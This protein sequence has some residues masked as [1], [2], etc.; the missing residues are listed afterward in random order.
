MKVVFDINQDQ[1]TFRKQFVYHFYVGAIF[2]IAYIV[3]GKPIIDLGYPGLVALLVLEI[4]ILSPLVIIHL[5]W[6]GKQLNRKFSFRNVI[7]YTEKLSIGQYIKW[8]LIGFF[9]C[10]IIYIPL[11][12][13]GL[14]IKENVFQWLPKWYF[15]PNFGTDDTGLIANVFLFAIFID[16]IL[17]P[18]LEELFFRGYLLPRMAYLKKWAPIVNGIFF[19]L[20][21]FWQPHNYLAIMGIG[22]VLSYIVWR[23]KNV[24]L[25]IFI[26]CTINIIG[27]LG[28]YLAATGGQIIP[29]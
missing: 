26:H 12:P 13:L 16:G 14:Y 1:I 24:Y 18:V 28:G 4:C 8:S 27:A 19:G 17:A 5:G 23:K 20:Y 3:I 25:G 21:H 22:V 9:G 7:A 29:R 15:D 11:F 10:L 2:L 6:K